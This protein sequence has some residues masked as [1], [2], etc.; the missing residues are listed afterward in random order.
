MN[1]I[2]NLRWVLISSIFLSSCYPNQNKITQL[3]SEIFSLKAQVKS[4]DE[5]I[6][7]LEHPINPNKK[8]ANN[9]KKR[10]GKASSADDIQLDASIPTT[11]QNS[12]INDVVKPAPISTHPSKSYSSPAPKTSNSGQ[13]QAITKKGS[14]CS[15][16]ARSGGYCWQHGG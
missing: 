2:N 13:C 8:K 6:T 14:R 4:L 5:R 10:T 15:R 9:L 11:D 3:E 12:Q 7:Y 1:Q 16:S